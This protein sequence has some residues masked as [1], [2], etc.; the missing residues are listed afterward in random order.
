M[1]EQSILFDAREDNPVKNNGGAE[2]DIILSRP[3]CGF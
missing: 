1:E 3:K 2:V